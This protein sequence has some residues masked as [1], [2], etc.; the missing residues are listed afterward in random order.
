MLGLGKGFGS[1]NGISS[2]VVASELGDSLAN[3]SANLSRDH[4]NRIGY[5]FRGAGSG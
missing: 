1:L 4:W 2:V 5:G 3:S